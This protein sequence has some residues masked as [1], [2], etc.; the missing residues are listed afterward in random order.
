MELLTTLLFWIPV[1]FVS[2]IFYILAKLKITKQ[3]VET[4]EVSHIALG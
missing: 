1:L 3:V 4:K 2:L